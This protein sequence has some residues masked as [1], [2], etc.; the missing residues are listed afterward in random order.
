MRRIQESWNGLAAAPHPHPSGAPAAPSVCPSLNPA[1]FPSQLKSQAPGSAEELRCLQ[2][3][4]QQPEGSSLEELSSSQGCLRLASTIKAYVA[5]VT[6]SIIRR[7]AVKEAWRSYFNT[8]EGQPP[9][10]I[11]GKPSAHLTLRP[12]SLAQD[13]ELGNPSGHCWV[14]KMGMGEIKGQ[15]TRMEEE[16]GG[17]WGEMS[18]VHSK[19]TELHRS[20][21]SWDEPPAS[22]AVPSGMTLHTGFPFGTLPSHWAAAAFPHGEQSTHGSRI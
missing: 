1:L 4:N 10:K 17:P 20:K 12:Q 13:G 14:S 15:G 2:A 22:W 19:T 8:S 18:P 7:S 16:L 9:P 11:A 21:S 5:T 3:L 6:E